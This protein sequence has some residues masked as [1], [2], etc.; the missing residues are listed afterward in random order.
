M[1]FFQFF[2]EK[3]ISETR[4][5]NQAIRVKTGRD[6]IFLCIY[7]YDKKF[8]LNIIFE[9]WPIMMKIK[10][11][12]FNRWIKNIVTNYYFTTVWSDNTTKIRW[13]VKIFSS[14]QIKDKNCSKSPKF[15]IMKEITPNLSV[16]YSHKLIFA[17]MTQ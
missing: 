13:W 16:T 5:I 4:S 6:R 9:S 1:L 14:N 11:H 15:C 17:D 7:C 3:A 8:V 2:Y 10:M 12:D